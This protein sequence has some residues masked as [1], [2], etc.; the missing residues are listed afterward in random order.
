MIHQELAVK[1]RLYQRLFQVSELCPKCYVTTKTTLHTLL[2]YPEIQEVWNKSPIASVI[3]RQQ[4]LEPWQWW[5]TLIEN[6]SKIGEA[7]KRMA[8]IAYL[9]WCVW[10]ARNSLI[11]EGKRIEVGDILFQALTYMKKSIFTMEGTTLM[12]NEDKMN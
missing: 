3:P 11:F 8:Q 4:N 2:F 7:K 12:Q 5:F 1:E 10:L 9:L 6:G